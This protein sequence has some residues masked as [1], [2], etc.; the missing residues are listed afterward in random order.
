MAFQDLDRVADPDGARSVRDHVLPEDQLLAE[1]AAAAEQF[2]G[3]PAA[4]PSR[5]IDR[6]DQAAPARLDHPEGDGADPDPAPSITSQ[7]RSPARP[8]GST[9]DSLRSTAR[10]ALSG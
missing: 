9:A 10:P 7:R 1:M 4:L 6:G 5:L 3:L 8:H 2:Q